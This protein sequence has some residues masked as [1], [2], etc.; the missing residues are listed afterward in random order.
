MGQNSTFKIKKMK[1]ICDI[2]AGNQKFQKIVNQAQQLNQLNQLFKSLIGN[3]L[4]QHCNLAK[5]DNKHL[6]VIA[7]NASWATKLRYTFPEILKTLKTQPEFAQVKTIKVLIATAKIAPA[8]PKPKINPQNA[9]LWA[10]IKKTL[11]SR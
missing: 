3:A 11:I 5:I 8:S 6:I 9:K 7:D 1:N 4:S 2:L 10:E